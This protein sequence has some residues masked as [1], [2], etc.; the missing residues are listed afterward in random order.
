MKYFFAK[1]KTQLPMSAI[2][3]TYNHDHQYFDFFD[4]L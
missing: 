2:S 4:S 1:K 3:E